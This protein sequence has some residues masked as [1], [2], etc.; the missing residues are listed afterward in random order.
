MRV[1]TEATGVTKLQLDLPGEH[2]AT[3]IELNN[4]YQFFKL[5]T[6]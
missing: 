5:L 2:L 4:T 3:M 6:E 1:H